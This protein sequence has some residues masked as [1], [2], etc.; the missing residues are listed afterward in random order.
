MPARHFIFFFGFEFCP[1]NSSFSL[2][3]KEDGKIHLSLPLAVI[4]TGLEMSLELTYFLFSVAGLA[5]VPVAD[6]A[7]GR[8]WLREL[9]AG[10]GAGAGAGVA[11]AGRCTLAEFAKMPSPPCTGVPDM[12]RSVAP[13][14]RRT[15]VWYCKFS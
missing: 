5:L 12:V 8:R 1:R 7:V 9:G 15:C 14:S 11:A 6:A 10:A 2:L 3:E 13:E 4:L